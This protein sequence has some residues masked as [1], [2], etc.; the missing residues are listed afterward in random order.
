MDLNQKL[1]SFREE[2]VE[3]RS[4]AADLAGKAGKEDLTSDEL[5]ELTEIEQRIGYLHDQQQGIERS[6]KIGA[7]SPNVN[8]KAGM[9]SKEQ[10][11]FS[12]LKLIKASAR[13]ATRKDRDDA[14]MELELS[15]DVEKRIGVAPRGV[16]LPM[17][18]MGAWEGKEIYE[19]KRSAYVRGEKRD[20]NATDFT[21][22]AA[23]IGVDFRPNQMIP[24]LRNAMALTQLNATYLD[25]LVGD[26]AIPKQTGA[27]TAGWIGS[28]GG[29]I[30]ESDQTVGMVT[31]TPRTVG[32]FTDYSRQLRLQSS[33]SV[34][35]FIRQDLAQVVALEKD[36]AAFHGTGSGG[37]PVGIANTTGIG[38][39]A[40]ATGSTPTRSEVVGM[41]GD[42]ASANALTGSLAFATESTVYSNMLDTVV[43]AGSGQ[44]LLSENG[45]LLGRQVVESNQITDG[46]MFFGNFSDLMV[47]EWGGYD[48]MVDPFTGATAGNV[49]ILIFHSCDIA[50]RHAESFTLGQ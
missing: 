8:D 50:V 17:E 27:A 11:E 35:N 2:E 9:N 7:F 34:E 15:A 46:Q 5:S 24:L 3:K 22:A 42:I 38:T 20:L 6:Q 43:D 18:V 41:R 45:T 12:M 37:Q 39:Q 23:L 31:L 13:D 1:T 44:F 21:G 48:L 28:D 30:G 10:R 14:A 40:F 16:Y 32:V 19:E 49:R 25:G 33:P 29:T 47:G 36:R 4:R 26:V